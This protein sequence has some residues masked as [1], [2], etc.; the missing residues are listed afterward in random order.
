MNQY[1]AFALL[2]NL[3]KHTTYSAGRVPGIQDPSVLLITVVPDF[4]SISSTLE[5][6]NLKLICKGANINRSIFIQDFIAIR[7]F[8]EGKMIQCNL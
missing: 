8:D 6:D 7:M 5:V 4:Q 3:P 2:I 1:E